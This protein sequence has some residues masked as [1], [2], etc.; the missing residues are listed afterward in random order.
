[1]EKS[2]SALWEAESPTDETRS[3]IKQVR[4]ITGSKF[5]PAEGMTFSPGERRPNREHYKL[6][7]SLTTNRGSLT[8]VT[9]LAKVSTNKLCLKG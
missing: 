8:E 9:H 3:F 4:H 2:P 7:K 6:E 1:M 5:T